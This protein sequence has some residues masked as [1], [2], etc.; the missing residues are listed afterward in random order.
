MLLPDAGKR[1]A[2]QMECLVPIINHYACVITVCAG[3]L[4]KICRPDK[5]RQK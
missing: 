4:Q 5:R 2:K 1:T 3:S